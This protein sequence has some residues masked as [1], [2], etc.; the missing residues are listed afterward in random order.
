MLRFK[1]GE[2]P[3]DIAA[4]THFDLCS[5]LRTTPLDSAK[6]R[7]LADRRASFRAPM[8][9]CHDLEAAGELWRKP[10]P[11]FRQLVTFEMSGDPVECPQKKD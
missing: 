5:G 1:G 2:I 6:R 10:Q 4:S 9:W 3:T 8:S 7:I 11:A